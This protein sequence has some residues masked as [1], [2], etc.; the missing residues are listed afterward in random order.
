M[1]VMEHAASSNEM[2][3]IVGIMDAIIGQLQRDDAAGARRSLSRANAIEM[4]EILK[5]AAEAIAHRS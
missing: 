2:S 4:C 1:D 5:G 3:A